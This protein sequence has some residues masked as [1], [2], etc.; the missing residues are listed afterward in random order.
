M[1]KYVVKDELQEFRDEIESVDQEKMEA[2]FGDV[3][4]SKINCAK[5]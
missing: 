2:E 1:A 5:F 3:L 4:F